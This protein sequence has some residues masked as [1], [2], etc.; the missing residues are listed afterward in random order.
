MP[1]NTTKARTRAKKLPAPQQV[2]V[3]IQ[4][5]IPT[6]LEQVRDLESTTSKLIQRIDYKPNVS[7]DTVGEALSLAQ[8]AIHFARTKLEK[9]AQK[10]QDN[11]LRK[12]NTEHTAGA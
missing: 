5:N 3:P 4:D 9:N 7:N 1:K 12:T 11:T 8:E 2:E 10:P 6:V